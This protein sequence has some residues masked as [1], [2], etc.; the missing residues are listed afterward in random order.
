MSP[1][2]TACQAVPREPTRYAATMVLPWPGSSACSA[3]SPAAT[4]STMATSP[5]SIAVAVIRSVKRSRGDACRTLLAEAGGAA[6]AAT[7]GNAVSE[8]PVV[9]VGG[10]RGSRLRTR[11]DSTS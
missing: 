3:P 4:T 7:G 6:G 10:C 1:S 11:R 2:S 8:D 5:G 9:A